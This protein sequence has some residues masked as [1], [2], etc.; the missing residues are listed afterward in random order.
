MQPLDTRA[1]VKHKIDGQ[2]VVFEKVP[3]LEPRDEMVFK[4]KC[5]GLKPGDARF[6]VEAVSDQQI[7]PLIKEE[8]TRI[9]GDTP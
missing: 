5:K 4:V 7:K 1:P 6:R 3:L 8:A 2:R 9:F